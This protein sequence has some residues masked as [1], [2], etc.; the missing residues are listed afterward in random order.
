[1]SCRLASAFPLFDVL[2]R[3]NSG[4]PVCPLPRASLKQ[5]F[6]I[7]IA[8][9]SRFPTLIIELLY[10]ESLQRFCVD[11]QNWQGGNGRTIREANALGDHQRHSDTPPPPLI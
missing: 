4:C 3:S 7:G 11:E 10:P 5:L 9:K 2:S 1:M 6:S 8:C